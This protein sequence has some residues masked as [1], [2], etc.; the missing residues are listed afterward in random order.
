MRILAVRGGGAQSV[1][2]VPNLA[3]KPKRSDNRSHLPKESQARESHPKESQARN[4]GESVDLEEESERF[5]SLFRMSSFAPLEHNSRSRADKRASDGN[6]QPSWQLGHKRQA[7]RDPLVWIDLEMTG[8]NLSKDTIIE[9]AC[10]VS[11]GTLDRQI[12]GP[13]IAIKHPDVVFDN[14]SEWCVKHHGKSGLTQRCKQSK[15]SMSGAEKQVL[16]F[17]RQHVEPNSAQLA[18]NSVHVDKA[19]LRKYMPTL[20]D[21]LHFRILDVSTLHEIA[22]RWFPKEWRKVPRRKNAHTAMSDI[23]ESVEELKYFRHALFKKV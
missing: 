9:I 8:L 6:G 2:S 15:T 7:L 5:K 1:N 21:Y 4:N 18:G 10:I 16:D 20:H 19:F 3:A 17:I 12:E 11:N 23:Q 13:S 14:M 22:R